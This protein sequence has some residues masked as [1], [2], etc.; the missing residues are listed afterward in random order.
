MPAAANGCDPHDVGM[1]SFDHVSL[2]GSEQ[3]LVGVGLRLTPTQGDDHHARI[4]LDGSYL[5]LRAGERPAALRGSGWFLRP[6]DPSR[7]AQTLAALDVDASDPT[8]FHG[9]DGTWSDI[10]V[11][12]G[13]LG[14]V[15]P[16]ITH[17]VDRPDWPPR[18]GTAHPNGAVAVARIELATPDPAAL[19]RLL[20]R[21]GA[22]ARIADATASPTAAAQLEL[23]R[24][25]LLV[26][27]G[28]EPALSVLTLRARDGRE[29]RIELAATS[30]GGRAGPAARS[31]GR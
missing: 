25:R 11:D 22:I 9:A 18:S 14:A 20:G 15:A 27:A 21:L 1:L 13:A 17:R 23:G 5:E 16:V 30:P 12:G 4:H 31:A 8:P 29:L 26:T 28:R 19:A 24:L 6:A 7:I 10:S 3:S 2:V